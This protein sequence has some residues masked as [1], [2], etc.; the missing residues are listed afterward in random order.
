[1]TM[2]NQR[3]TLRRRI[4]PLTMKEQFE[5]WFDSA[6]DVL[7]AVEIPIDWNRQDL[8]YTRPQQVS[9]IWATCRHDFMEIDYLRLS[10]KEHRK[11]HKLLN[12]DLPAALQR[13]MQKTFT[14]GARE[15]LRVPVQQLAPRVGSGR[16]A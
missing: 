4:Q 5:Q 9:A 6:A 8:G 16:C 1:M 15:R 10:G 2:V 7:R 14:K 13:Y 11:L 3:A 12:R